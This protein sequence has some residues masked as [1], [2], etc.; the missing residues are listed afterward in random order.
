MVA[1]FIGT[2]ALVF[3]G[4]GSVMVLDRFEGA[5][6]PFVVPLVFGLTV[7]SMIYAVG[8]ISGAHFNPAVTLGFAI[9]RHFPKNQIIAY[10]LAQ[11]MGGILAIFLLSFLLPT[12]ETYGATLPLIALEKAVIWEAILSFFLMFVIISVATDT[13]AIGIMAGAA[14]GATVMFCAFLGGPVTGASMNPARTLA[15]NLFQG[16]LSTLWIYFVGPCMGTILAAIV[17]EKIKCFETKKE[18]SECC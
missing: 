12:G 11:F 2:F 18:T 1:E 8:H 3:A 16:E 5:F 15:P 13:R 10:W 4:C 7:A 9:G 17:Y 6:S 14:I